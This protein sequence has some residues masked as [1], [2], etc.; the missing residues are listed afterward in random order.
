MLSVQGRAVM[1][2]AAALVACGACGQIARAAEF[3]AHDTE[4]HV[5]ADERGYVD[6]WELRRDVARVEALEILD[7]RYACYP[8]TDAGPDSPARERM[9]D[10]CA[11]RTRARLRAY[12]EA[13]AN[14]NAAWQTTLREAIE[15]G[16]PIAEIVMRQC[17][18]TNVLDRSDFESTCDTDTARRS[19]AAQR[20]REI[21]FAPAFDR[22]GEAMSQ[23]APSGERARGEIQ[24]EIL[25]A[26]GSGDFAIDTRGAFHGGNAPY[27]AEERAEI[28]GDEV[29]HAAWFDAQRAFTLPPGW[30]SSDGGSDGGSLRL[31]RRQATRGQLTWGPQVLGGYTRFWRTGPKRIHLNHGSQS[32][33]SIGDRNDAEFMRMRAQTLS[34][35]QATIDHWLEQD[36]RWGVFLLQRVG[37][38]EWVPYGTQSKTGAL[39]PEWRGE[40]TLRRSFSD[41]VVDEDFESASAT[42]TGDGDETW[43]TFNDSASAA[44][45]GEAI[46]CRLRY[47]GGT[48]LKPWTNADEPEW[49]HTALG[50]LSTLA[51]KPDSGQWRAALAPLDA[52]K[53]YRQVLVQCPEGESADSDRARFLLL[54]GDTLVEVEN[55]PYVHVSGE[56]WNPPP[57]ILRHYRRVH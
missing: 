9:V 50:D 7:G 53:R 17:S 34:T 56:A 2:V 23:P 12:R 24:R 31:N 40:W 55:R 52:A 57:L 10:E 36:P 32:S 4:S 6:A 47:S 27:S 13:L 20:L 8:D 5:A 14:F 43:I 28:L 46:R 44:E 37:W 21:G 45:S 1:V 3:A 54:A 41:W 33:E 39:S 49:R 26:Y 51:G 18:T 19:V 25:A 22:E 30:L 48:T 15:K 35:A 16:D 11:A 29:I 38:H 42:V